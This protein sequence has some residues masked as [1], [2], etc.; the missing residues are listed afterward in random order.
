MSHTN[1][2]SDPS[3]AGVEDTA[4][5][6]EFLQERS[7]RPD[8]VQVNS[9]VRDALDPQAGERLLE[10]G[11]GTG[12]V[13]RLAAPSVAPHGSLIGLDISTEFART[14]GKATAAAG[15]SEWVSYTAGQAERLPF[16]ASSFE[17][18]WAVRLLLHV[19]D[20]QQVVNE[21]ARVVRPAGRIVLADWDFET[22]AVDHSDRELTRRLLTWRID[23]HGGDNW[24]GRQLWRQARQAGL[25]QISI[26]PLVTVATDESAALTQSLW[27][28]AEVALQGGR[29][30][31]G[32]HDA[33]VGELKER[34]AVGC[35][36]TS[37]VYFIV[38]GWI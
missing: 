29:I 4:R 10:V 31:S 32:E 36:F 30:T 9:A 24:S 14:A 17:A 7:A 38:K 15:L 13:C 22:V 2:W 1:A 12:V 34:I 28:A 21:M 6:A 33:W 23:H 5:M 25:K 26:M 18:A 37:I 8:Q 16:R 3:R 27:R 20:P 35:F 19:A 11:S